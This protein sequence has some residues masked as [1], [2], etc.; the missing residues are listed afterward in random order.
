MKNFLKMIES[1]LANRPQFVTIN[2]STSTQKTITCGV[3]QGSIL[4]PLSPFLCITDLPIV[5]LLFY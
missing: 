1:Y 2:N 5:L 4:G 3:P